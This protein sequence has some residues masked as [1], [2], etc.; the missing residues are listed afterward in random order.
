LIATGA[1][2]E[3]VAGSAVGIGHLASQD[4]CINESLDEPQPEGI[5]STHRAAEGR[6][7]GAAGPIRRASNQFIPKSLAIT[8]AP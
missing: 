3:R 5:R 7:F 4:G 1:G 8:I 6:G 2:A